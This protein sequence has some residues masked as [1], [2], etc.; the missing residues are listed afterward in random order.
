MDDQHQCQDISEKSNEKEREIAIE[1]GRPTVNRLV[2][3]ERHND[4]SFAGFPTKPDAF[5]PTRQMR[6]SSGNSRWQ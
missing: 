4:E 1:I 3:F 5:Q 6:F 2:L